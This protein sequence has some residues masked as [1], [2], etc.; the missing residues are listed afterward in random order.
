MNTDKNLS[1]SYPCL[2]V[3]IRGRF[4]DREAVVSVKRWHA[5]VAARSTMRITTTDEH[6][7]E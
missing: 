6:G 5:R 7:Q 1:L 3:F 2:S 4:S